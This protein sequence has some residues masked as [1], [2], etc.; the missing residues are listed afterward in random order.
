MYYKVHEALAE[1]IRKPDLLVYLQAST[2][3]LMQ[4]IAFRD[5][6]Y[7]RQMERSYIDDLNHAYES[8]FAK[9]FDHTPV[10]TI[11]TNS[12]NIV[13]N[14]EHLK[15]IENRI[16]QSLNLPPFQQSLPLPN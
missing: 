4:R 16:R 9:P 10:L 3:T 5:R 11:D 2:D 6:A 1:K 8:F 12:L 15:L 14:A 13:Q 7:E